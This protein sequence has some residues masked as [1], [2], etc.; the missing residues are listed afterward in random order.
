MRRTYKRVTVDPTTF[1]ILLDGKSALTPLG[2]PLVLPHAALAEAIAQEWVEQE[3]EIRK[4]TMPLT[5]IA[6]V[7]ID[8][9]G[10]KRNDV[11]DDILEYADTDLV[12]YRAG[13]IPELQQLQDALLNRV[14]QCVTEQLGIQLAITSDL[15]PVAQPI[16]NK[17]ILKKVFSRFSEWKLAGLISVTKSLG[18][19]I[20]AFALSENHITGAEAFRLSHLEEAYE[21]ECWGQDEEKSSS[22]LRME[23][24]I[25]AV[26]RYFSLLNAPVCQAK[27][28]IN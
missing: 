3:N 12:C 18:S 21:T 2:M 17:P 24:E 7:A 28:E 10:H 26:E 1:G 14:I 5:H 22:M 25:L 4:Y 23:Q 16:I 20:L 6:C 27:T 8:V 11:T 19:L 13:N 9:V 15:M